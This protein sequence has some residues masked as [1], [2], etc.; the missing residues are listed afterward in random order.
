MMLLKPR[1]VAQRLNV[2][3]STVYGLVE[4]GKLACHRIGCR[5][6]AVRVSEQ[7]LDAYVASCRNGIDD[8]PKRTPSRVKLK[9]VHL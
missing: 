1:D 2:S 8:Q 9:H 3:L 4:S 5:R 6:G 7:D